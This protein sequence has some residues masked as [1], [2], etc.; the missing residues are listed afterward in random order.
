[1]CLKWDKQVFSNNLNEILKDRNISKK[2]LANLIDKSESSIAKYCNC[3]EQ[4]IPDIECVIAMAEALGVRINDLILE[5]PSRTVIS[6]YERN[7]LLFIDKIIN[8]TKEEKI[9]WE[10][11]SRDEYYSEF[12]GYKKHPLFHPNI[13]MVDNE[14]FAYNYI[15]K[16]DEDYFATKGFKTHINGENM[17]LVIMC[18]DRRNNLLYEIYMETQNEIHPIMCCKSIDTG[19]EGL[20]LELF[21]LVEFCIYDKKP[22]QILSKAFEKFLT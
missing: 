16:F 21:K 11:D 1:M 7:K 10:L 20:P 3:R 9:I 4:T 12:S 22:K 5:Q 14:E 13:Y 19:N 18:S 17:V 2:E 15:S 6:D 8:D